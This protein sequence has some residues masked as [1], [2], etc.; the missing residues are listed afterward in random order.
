MC[1]LVSETARNHY[2]PLT[3]LTNL[4]IPVDTYLQEMRVVLYVCL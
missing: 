2:Q 3:Y 4:Y 1:A